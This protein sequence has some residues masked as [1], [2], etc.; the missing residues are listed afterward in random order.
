LE[1][2]KIHS[3]AGNMIGSQ[4]GILKSRPFRSPHHTVSTA[5]LTGGGTKSLPGEISLAH[6]GVLFLDELPEFAKNSLEA[7]RQPL[8]D[9]V[10]SVAR[11]NAKMTYPASFMLICAMNPCPCG[12]FGNP[13]KECRCT[14]MQIRNYI[15]RIS[16]PFL[17]RIDM[18]LEMGP[19]TYEEFSGDELAE[20]TTDIKSR[21]D[22]AR[23]TQLHRYGEDKL[24]C[25]AQLSGQQIKQYCPLNKESKAMLDKAYTAFSY[26]ARALSRITKVARTIADLE[27][28]KEIQ[29]KHIAE[30]LQYRT[31][32]RKYW[33]N[34]YEV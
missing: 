26:S 5:A 29:A 27:N 6:N 25:N 21:V 11:V 18:H 7:L 14:P 23:K 28:E 20:T 24:Y 30:A 17:D 12:N 33:G 2:T 13:Q 22:H 31:L 34:Y 10:V 15:N 9:G 16:G 32:D 4:S 19:I 1:V 8:E 3:I